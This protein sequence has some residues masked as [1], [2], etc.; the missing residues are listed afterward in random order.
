MGSAL[1]RPVGCVI[2]DMD[3][4]LLDTEIFY[5]R[6][7]QRI[8]ARYGRT[9]DW[10]LKSNMVGR[11]AIESARYLVE[12][13]GIPL[14]P[15]E[16][17]EEREAELIRWM[18]DAV[19]MPGAETLTR[20]LAGAGM[21]LAVATS[22]S[23]RFFDLKTTRHRAWFESTFAAIVVGDDP[24]VGAG[25]PAPDIFLC[26]AAALGAEP[27]DC[28]VVED[29]PAGVR[30]ARAAGM[31]VVAVPYPGMDPERVADADL[32]ASSLGELSVETFRAPPPRGAA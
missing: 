2:F 1:A 31:Q 12:T 27:A 11:P 13:L 3:G 21:R 8:V 14:R 17:L 9:F 16:Y 24:R 5:T 4:V 23:R 28:A 19:P 29:S 30:A 26:A 18:P 22:S 20:A 6:V 7:T 10:S 25:K 15:E 32:L